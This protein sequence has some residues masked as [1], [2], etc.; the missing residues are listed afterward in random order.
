MN[1][2]I[3]KAIISRR[4]DEPIFWFIYLSTLDPL[5]NQVSSDPLPYGPNLFLKVPVHSLEPYNVFFLSL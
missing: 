3:N 1:G 4:S 5:S 2:V